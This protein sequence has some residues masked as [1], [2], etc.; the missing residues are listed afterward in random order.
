MESTKWSAK[1]IENWI[2]I[3]TTLHKKEELKHKKLKCLLIAQ[4]RKSARI[5]SMAK[6][7][8]I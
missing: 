7:K 8:K 2:S 5:A 1:T 6:K 3:H 4:L